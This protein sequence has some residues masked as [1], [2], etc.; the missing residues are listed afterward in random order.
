MNIAY[1]PPPEDVME[2]LAAEVARTT[3]EVARRQAGLAPDPALELDLWTEASRTMQAWYARWP[4][5]GPPGAHEAWREGLLSD[6]ADAAHRLTLRHGARWS[7]DECRDNLCWELR[8][9]LSH[10]PRATGPG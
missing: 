8:P 4:G 1:G 5:E 2:P 6:L 3:F 7:L 10:W 9:V